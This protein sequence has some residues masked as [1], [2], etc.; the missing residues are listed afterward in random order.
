MQCERLARKAG[1][2]WQTFPRLTTH[3]YRHSDQIS[4]RQIFNEKF[5][6]S[7]SR[8]LLNSVTGRNTEWEEYFTYRQRVNIMARRNTEEPGLTHDYPLVV[9]RSS[10]HK[11]HFSWT[12]SRCIV[13]SLLWTD[14]QTPSAT[15]MQKSMVN[16]E[17]F[18]TPQ[19]FFECNLCI[20]YECSLC[21]LKS[22]LPKLIHLHLL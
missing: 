1:L 18:P 4:G 17:Q 20:H 6:P 16:L 19:D 2:Q 21:I 11:Q 5:K 7:S 13:G 3:R 8:N 9:G 10:Q 12:L 15:Q 22:I 14:V